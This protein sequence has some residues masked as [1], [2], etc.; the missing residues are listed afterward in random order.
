MAQ[1]VVV[2]TS[3]HDAI[4]ARPRIRDFIAGIGAS[5]TSAAEVELV[6]TELASNM[7]QHAGMG[8]IRLS[9]VEAPNPEVL[10]EAEDRG[11]GLPDGAFR[12]GFSTRGGLG[13]GL[14]TVRR[15]SDRLDVRSGLNGTHIRAWKRL[16]ST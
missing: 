7:W 4:V 10:I 6:V 14:G 15:M 12:D 16:S 13:A 2:I 9:T 8:E 11:P 1:I 5:A 3:H